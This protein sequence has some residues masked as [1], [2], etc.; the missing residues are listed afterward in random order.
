MQAPRFSIVIPSYGRPDVLNR[1]LEDLKEQENF[2]L[3]AMEVIIINEENSEE[4]G[5]LARD[6]S[7]HFNVVYL[8]P[9]TER[10]GSSEARNIGIS[11]AKGEFV[12]FLDDD[13]RVGRDFLSKCL[14]LAKEHQAF[15]FRIQ[16]PNDPRPQIVKK[17]HRLFV[18]RVF[19]LLGIIFGGFEL[20]DY[21]RKEIP[22]E[23]F[24]GT[25]FVV[26]RELIADLRFDEYLGKGNGYLEDSDFTYSLHRKGCPLVF[27]TNYSVLHLRAPR[28]GNRVHDPSVWLNERW[29]YFYWNHKAYFVKKW[30]GQLKLLSATFFNFV[31]CIALSLLTRKLLF[32]VFVK[33]WF[34]GIRKRHR[35]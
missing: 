7:N 13:V 21:G 10:L 20:E 19:L 17:I 35:A 9:S 31:E 1:L 27:V 23:H 4:Y 24:P 3:N 25:A 5:K 22:V 33:G 34:D 30:G 18:G 11:S 12:V 26:K 28:G 16:Q 29:L 2:E 6:F 32:R 14:E 8:V 15:S